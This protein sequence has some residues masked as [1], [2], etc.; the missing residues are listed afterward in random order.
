MSRKVT[1]LE[2]VE[3]LDKE[4][5]LT[6]RCESLLEVKKT[7]TVTREDPIVFASGAVS[8]GDDPEETGL[9]FVSDDLFELVEKETAVKMHLYLEGVFTSDE[10]Y[11][12]VM[13]AL[14]GRADIQIHEVKVQEV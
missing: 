12:I 9:I 7:F 8:F 1:A 14:R 11:T 6:L 4:E 5:V 3:L 10:V 13:D 2:I